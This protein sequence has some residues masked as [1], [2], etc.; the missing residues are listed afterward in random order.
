M[1]ELNRQRYFEYQRGSV[2]QGKTL[3]LVKAKV[4]L[5]LSVKVKGRGHCNLEIV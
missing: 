1:K 5:L 4:L 2:Y 3:L